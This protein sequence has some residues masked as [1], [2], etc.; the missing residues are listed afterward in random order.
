MFPAMR[1]EDK[2]QDTHPCERTKQVV[3]TLEEAAEVFLVEV[4]P[5]SHC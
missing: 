2:F 4:I 5:E 3:F 1:A